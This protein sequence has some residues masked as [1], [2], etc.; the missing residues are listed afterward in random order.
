MITEAKT[1]LLAKAAKIAD[2]RW[3]A[4]FL[5]AIPENAETLALARQWMSPDTTT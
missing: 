3:R 4:C 1:E 2:E 5:E